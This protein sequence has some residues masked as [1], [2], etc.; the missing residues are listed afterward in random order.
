[1]RHNRKESKERNTAVKRDNT[2]QRGSTIL[3]QR[4]LPPTHVPAEG[5]Q[6]ESET[7][8]ITQSSAT[9]WTVT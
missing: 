5:G 3:K 7:E 1:M 2:R 6:A 8:M 9:H 4:A